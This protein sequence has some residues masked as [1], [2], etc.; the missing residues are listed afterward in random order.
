MRSASSRSSGLR[1]GEATRRV[2]TRSREV[3]V[4]VVSAVMPGYTQAIPFRTGN[5]I[6][7]VNGHGTARKALDPSF[8]GERVNTTDKYRKALMDT[9]D[10]YITITCTNGHVYV[11]STKEA[12]ERE[13]ARG[14]STTTCGTCSFPFD[15]PPTTARRRPRR[16]CQRQIDTRVQTRECISKHLRENPCSK[17]KGFFYCSLTKK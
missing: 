2:S 3:E 1:G 8:Q 6:E 17:D 9:T 14:T 12:L 7:T 16:H 10:G 4:L 15:T 11:L 5:L 13:R